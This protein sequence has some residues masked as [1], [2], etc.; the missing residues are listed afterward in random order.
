MKNPFRFS[1][2]GVVLLCLFF[3]GCSQ[4]KD[5]EAVQNK[6]KANKE[7]IITLAGYRDLAP[8]PRFFFPTSLIC[9]TWESLV[10]VQSDLFSPKPELSVSWE[11]SDD[12]RKWTFHLRKG[13]QFQDGTLFNADAVLAN[14]KRYEKAPG[15]NKFYRFRMD[16]YYPGFSHIE[17]VDDYTVTI[18]FSDPLPGLHY[19]MAGWG[20]PI[21]SPACFDQNSGEFTSQPMGTG[22]FVVEKHEPDQYVVLKRFEQYWDVKTETSL[23]RIQVIPDVHTRYSAM[24]AGEIQGIIDLGGMMPILAKELEEDPKFNLSLEKNSILH[25]VAVNGERFPFN[26]ERMRR[27]FSLNIDRDLISKE[28]FSGYFPPAASILSH[29]SPFFKSVQTVYEPEQAKVLAQEVLKG[30][31]AKLE[32][33]LPSKLFNYP[34]KEIAQY[35]QAI[36]VDLGLDITI[37]QVEAGGMSETLLAGEYNLYIRRQGLPHADPTGIFE[38]YMRFEGKQGMHQATQNKRFHYNYENPKA[39]ALLESLHQTIDMDKRGVIFNQLQDL[40][41]TTFPIIPLVNEQTIV[42]NSHD[43]QGYEAKVYGATLVTAK[44]GH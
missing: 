18:F 26:D 11:K 43:L 8:G 28:F 25:F 30:K 2:L 35:L 12:A 24:K 1:I 7:K 41:A 22:P 27:A 13:V 14:F 38:D 40:A 37:R 16:R 36:M 6:K 44:K 42:V 9:R 19:F 10:G 32:L 5:G 34:Y 39:T 29:A 15:K 3:G 31:R 17:K 4:D 23:V 20:S 21:F 33:L